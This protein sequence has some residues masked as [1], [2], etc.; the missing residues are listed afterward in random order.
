M[1]HTKFPPRCFFPAGQTDLPPNTALTGSQ[2]QQSANYMIN[3]LASNMIYM[4]SNPFDTTYNAVSGTRYV[5]L[6]GPEKTD[7]DNDDRNLIV[8]F[9]GWP[10]DLGA[11]GGGAA[12]AWMKWTPPGGAAQT[13]Y[14][15]DVTGG[16]G[17]AATPAYGSQLFL[18]AARYAYYDTSGDA[19][20]WTPN[21]TDLLRVGTITTQNFQLA[22]LSI[23]EAPMK[24]LTPTQEAITIDSMGAGMVIRGKGDT[25]NL[26]SLGGLIERVQDD[27]DHVETVERMTRRMWQWGHVEG[28][29]VTGTT[30]E[31]LHGGTGGGLNYQWKPRQLSLAGDT[32]ECLPFAVVTATNNG[33]DSYLQYNNITDADTW[34][35]QGNNKS[36]ALITFA[37][38]TPATGIDF[39]SDAIAEFSIKL[40]VDSGETFTVHT[41]GIL[42]GAQLTPP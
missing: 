14:E 18:N 15:L 3:Y 41:G 33:N 38:G 4:E 32:V 31:W 16:V 21:G 12:S 22:A 5:V 10:T 23:W 34:T 37:D 28:R 26:L 9:I 8:A 35:W 29:Q 25:A 24:K 13:I 17:L 36:A 20:V 2:A 30:Y 19:L 7:T 42:E 11:P 40:K 27:D 6:S 39:E 1:P